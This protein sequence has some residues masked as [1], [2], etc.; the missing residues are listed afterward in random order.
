MA[1][2]PILTASGADLR[3]T[4]LEGPLAG[5]SRGSRQGARARLAQ[6]GEPALIACHVSLASRRSSHSFSALSCWETQASS[7]RR[8]CACTPQDGTWLPGS[9]RAQASSAAATAWS[10]L[11]TPPPASRRCTAP[12]GCTRL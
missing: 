6:L 1:S 7:R 9:S 3:K 5:V 10:A 12:Q 2:S 8:S 11:S 4:P